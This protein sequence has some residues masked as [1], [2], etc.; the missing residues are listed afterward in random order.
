MHVRGKCS[1]RH[2][3]TVVW[4]SQKHPCR[5]VGHLE[6]SSAG[7][8]WGVRLEAGNGNSPCTSCPRPCGTVCRC[9]CGLEERAVDMWW[10]EFR[11]LHD[12][13]QVFSANGCFP[14][15]R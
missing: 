15:K 11:R 13:G 12:I 9:R 2:C 6:P 14:I 8:V 7:I 1:G 5:F 10:I 3:G 4:S